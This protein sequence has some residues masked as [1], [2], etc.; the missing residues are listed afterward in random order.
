MGTG[1]T[2]SQPMPRLSAG[3]M[4]FTKAAAGGEHSC[5]ISS[6][7]TF[8]WG[9]NSIG[10]I[11][12]GSPSFTPHYQPGKVS[13]AGA[14]TDIEANG[15]AGNAS[16]ADC[17]DAT[18]SAGTCAVTASGDAACWGD[19]VTLATPSSGTLKFSNIS[20]GWD[21]DCGLSTE[22]VGYCWGANY[23]LQSGGPPGAGGLSPPV[24][25]P[26][27]IDV[28]HPLQEISANRAHSC[29]V[30]IQGFVFCWGANTS[31]QLGAAASG[32]CVTQHLFN[33]P[34]RNTPVR[35]MTDQLF[36]SVSV[37]STQRDRSDTAPASHTCGITVTLDIYCWG[38]NVYGQ[39]G[40]GVQT[41]SQ[42]PVRVV[43]SEKFSKV[44]AERGNTC[45]LT[46]AGVAWC[47]GQNT[48][49]RFAGRTAASS[50][51]SRKGGGGLTFR[52]W[53]FACSGGAINFP[54]CYS[55]HAKSR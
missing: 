53:W 17:T 28:G 9:F 34:C 26:L 37:G 49:P 43:S 25:S 51:A 41:D 35:V 36:Q 21:Y 12:D 47:W 46:T 52:Y 10:T 1:D 14:F 23:Y 40:N 6:G 54:P 42:Q 2:Q 16:A 3:G 7:G 4:N 27:A 44:V 19:G 15:G 8:C 5:G 11:G 30:T 20:V 31:G 18:C 38:S 32:T 24:N 29:A 55:A 50:I 48:A 39:L 13:N 45:A 22:K 33:I